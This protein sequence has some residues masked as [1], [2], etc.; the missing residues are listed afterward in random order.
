MDSGNPTIAVI[1]IANN[2][3]AYIDEW[4]A[5]HL[6]IGVDKIVVVQ[7]N[8]RYSWAGRWLGDERVD[9]KVLD[10][11]LTPTEQPRWYNVVAREY[12]A[13]YD[14]V[15]A[16]D[17]DEFLVL[18]KWESIGAFLRANKGL[19][20]I[21]I[22][23]RM[24]GDNGIRHF[25]ERNASVLKRF[26]RGGKSLFSN[27]KSIF[28]TDAKVLE[29]QNAHNLQNKFTKAREPHNVVGGAE[30]FHFRNK[31]YEERQGRLPNFS[32]RPFDETFNE[33]NANEKRDTTARDF[34]YPEL[35]GTD[36]GID[37]KKYFDRIYCVFFVPNR[38]RLDR[39]DKEFER[40]GIKNSGIFEY[41]WS[42]PSVYD[43]QALSAC[44]EKPHLPIYKPAY[45]NHLRH[46]EEIL[47]RAQAAK[48]ERILILEDDIAFLKSLDELEAVLGSMPVGYAAFQMDK[49]LLPSNKKAWEELRKTKSL[50]EYW[51]D[52]KHTRFTSAACTAF[53][54]EGVEEMLRVIDSTKGSID[55]LSQ[56]FKLPWAIAKVN[57]CIQVVYK[58]AVNVTYGELERLHAVYDYLNY[59]AYETPSGYQRGKAL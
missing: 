36:E 11:D 17:I 46:V 4:L 13:I 47:R 9:F 48:Y 58:N 15:G 38:N 32:G 19:R 54:R 3:D 52:S 53:S 39:L 22:P 45:A 43:S 31:T 23:W 14:Y 50:N 1:A 27:G 29:W 44:H 51:L 8:W 12:E 35:K 26:T 40:V 21:F 30:M 55:Q 2:E 24:F 18:R 37:W 6:K 57:A 25:D 56:N 28:R 42:T 41:V 16:W 5:Y 49:F 20:S 34:L 33:Y 59:G 10:G 7:N